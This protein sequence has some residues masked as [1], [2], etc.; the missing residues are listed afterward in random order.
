M[1]KQSFLADNK[2]VGL[3]RQII[4]A[5]GRPENKA[6]LSGAAAGGLLTGAGD[7]G[8]QLFRDDAAR[9]NA[10]KNRWRII[11]AGMLGGGFVGRARG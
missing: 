9:K 7:V 3:A 5:M 10:A 2:E 1:I 8:I 6:M 11:L 4:E